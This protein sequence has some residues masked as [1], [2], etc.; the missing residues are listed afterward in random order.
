MGLN[1]GS[2]SVIM[3]FAVLCLTVLCALSLL[4]ANAQY[5]VAVRSKNVVSRFYAADARAVEIYEFIAAGDVEAARDLATSGVSAEELPS[6]FESSGSGNTITYQVSLRDEADTEAET[7]GEG[8][9]GIARQRI[10]VV[11]DLSGGAAQIASWTLA[12]PDWTPRPEDDNPSLF[13]P[14]ELWED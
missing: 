12:D 1:M 10:V 3:L 9:R 5:Q 7:G 8:S 2:A 14:T 6:A 4:S 11:V 13:D